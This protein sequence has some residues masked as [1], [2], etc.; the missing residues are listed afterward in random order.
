MTDDDIET[1]FTG[2]EENNLNPDNTGRFVHVLSMAGA[3]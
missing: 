2:E 1:V 3:L